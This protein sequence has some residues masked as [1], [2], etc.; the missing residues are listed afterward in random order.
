MPRAK[1][2]YGLG[3]FDHENTTELLRIGFTHGLP[4][5]QIAEVVG[6]PIKQVPSD[7]F[8]AE[9]KT[10]PE[11]WP[12]F[13]GRLQQAKDRYP[14]KADFFGV[15]EELVRYRRD[16]MP[17]E[18][19]STTQSIQAINIFN[20][21]FL[22]S[23]SLA[24]E[25]KDPFSEVVERY[26]SETGHSFDSFLCWRLIQEY[27]LAMLPAPLK[28]VPNPDLGLA[29]IQI[30]RGEYFGTSPLIQDENAIEIDRKNRAYQEKGVNDSILARIHFADFDAALNQYQCL[31]DA[32][33]QNHPEVLEQ[34]LQTCELVAT[35]NSGRKKYIKAE[36]LTRT[37]FARCEFCYQFRIE[38]LCRGMSKIPW[39]CPSCKRHYKTWEK[40]LRRSGLNLNLALGEG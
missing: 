40:R 2:D 16:Q 3:Y 21:S 28:R 31:I 7:L 15:F 35:S 11:R 8:I 34:I 25:R 6:E 39:H 5:P 37:A 38:H 10:P 1:S 32:I 30:S 9:L 22:V 18:I 36:R 13:E 20:R 27:C 4:R 26:C 14:N 29:S 12:W 24:F 33:A 17:E 23:A 19:I